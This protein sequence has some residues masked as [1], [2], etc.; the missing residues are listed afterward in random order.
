MKF[1]FDILART[2]VI[3]EYNQKF[4]SHEKPL[5]TMIFALL[6]ARK[7]IFEGFRTIF[8]SYNLFSYGPGYFVWLN[9]FLTSR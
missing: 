9:K 7:N 2:Y 5:K 1:V 4:A 3:L 8:L 6:F